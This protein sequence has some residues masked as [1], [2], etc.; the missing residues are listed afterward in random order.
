MR[1]YLYIC[2]PSPDTSP[3]T[4][5]PGTFRVNGSNKRMRELQQAFETPPRVRANPPFPPPLT[6]HLP[7]VRQRPGLETG[8]I[9]HS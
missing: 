2:S 7:A 4:E 6:A 9:Y 8:N 3:A 5:V 1:D